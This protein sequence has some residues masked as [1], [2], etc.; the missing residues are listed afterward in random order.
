MQVNEAAVSYNRR[1]YTVEEYLEMESRSDVKHEYYR[2]EIFAMSGAKL[3]HNIITMNLGTALKEKLKGKP[4]R[5]YGSDMRIRIV[6]WD[7]FTYPD[8]S[9]ICGEPKSM[10]DDQFNFLN[11]TIIFEV[12]ST[13]TSD[14]DRGTKFKF[15]RDIPTLKEYVLIDTE[16]IAIE[17]FYINDRGHWELNEYKNSSDTLKLRSILVEI[18]LTDI[19][20]DTA[21]AKQL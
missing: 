7:L 5:P 11:P 9:V 10:N 18:P 15:Y 21:V 4:C 2:G 16:A 12:A 8:M 6:Q 14:Y 20:E 1:R 17:I 3:Q 13:S 19:Y